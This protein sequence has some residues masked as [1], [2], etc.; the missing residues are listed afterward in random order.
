M[1]ILHKKITNTKLRNITVLYI[2]NSEIFSSPQKCGK[3]LLLFAIVVQIFGIFCQSL[4]V[5]WLR[6]SM[7]GNINNKYEY[8]LAILDCFCNWYHYL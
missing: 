5:S 4:R 8:K 2:C 6:R 1:E 7:F 3:W